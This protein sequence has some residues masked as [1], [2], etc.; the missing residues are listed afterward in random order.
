MRCTFVLLA[1]LA[2]TPAWAQTPAPSPAPADTVKL[3]RVDELERENIRLLA[4][5]SELQ[6][7]VAEARLQAMSTSLQTRASTWIERMAK[8]HPGYDI[9]PETL[10]LVKKTPRDVPPPK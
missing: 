2:S 4:L 1:L 5:V 7:Q 9:N 10:E 6:K 8:Q 3:E